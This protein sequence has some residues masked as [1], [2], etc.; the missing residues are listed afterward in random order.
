MPSLP[1]STRA[2]AVFINMV[3]VATVPFGAIPTVSKVLTMLREVRSVLGNFDWTFKLTRGWPSDRGECVWSPSNWTCLPKSRT[4]ASLYRQSAPY[5]RYE[6][7]QIRRPK[8]KL[9][10]YQFYQGEPYLRRLQH[11][12]DGF[13]IRKTVALHNAHLDVVVLFVVRIVLVSHDPLQICK[14]SAGLK[15]SKELFVHYNLLWRMFDRFETESGIQA[16]IL[17]RNVMEVALIAR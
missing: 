4:K 2:T 9:A 3:L 16:V 1:D 11:F 7:F 14:A 6:Q 5:L 17:R 8:R 13:N 15:Y 12:V 10:F